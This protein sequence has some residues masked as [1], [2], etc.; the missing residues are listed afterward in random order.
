MHRRDSCARPASTLTLCILDVAGCAY[1]RRPAVLTVA[2]LCIGTSVCSTFSVSMS[3]SLSLLNVCML[4]IYGGHTKC[5]RVARM[6]GWHFIS[7][8]S[9]VQ[10]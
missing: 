3:S 7:K 9:G 5:G 4:N 1:V 6:A 8:F 2:Y 10:C